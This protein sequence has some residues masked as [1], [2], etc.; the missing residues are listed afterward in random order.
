MFVHPSLEVSGS[1]QKLCTS[2][3]NICTLQLLQPISM[4]G[5][6]AVIG[7]TILVYSATVLYGSVNY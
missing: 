1:V 3:N 6:T 4:A 7:N 2:W 5:T